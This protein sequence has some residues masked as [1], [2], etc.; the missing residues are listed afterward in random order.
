MCECR[1]KLMAHS[2]DL[3]RTFG[4]RNTLGDRRAGCCT[5]GASA[6]AHLPTAH[7]DG[8]D[9]EIRLL[10]A[11]SRGAWSRSGRATASRLR[12]H[13]H[14]IGSLAG[15]RQP[16]GLR[17]VRGI[18]MPSTAGST[19]CTGSQLARLAGELVTRCREITARAN[20]STT[21]IQRRSRQ[22]SPALLAVQG[23]GVLPA[24][25]IGE[26]A[27]VQR[28]HSKDA[29]A[30]HNGSAPLRVGRPIAIRRPAASRMGNRQLNAARHA[31]RT[32]PRLGTTHRLVDISHGGKRPAAAPKRPCAASS[33]VT[34]GRRVSSAR[35]RP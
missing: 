35:C 10:L 14:E 25:I 16:D 5:S 29:F 13:L 1:A 21:E 19:P 9:R 11:S 3:A 15:S 6:S 34:L 27:G 33:D 28:F 20:D 23:C 8:P 30:K 12:W 18:S 31:H 22:L 32:S 7:L 2:R 26:T 24:K 17:H 4:V